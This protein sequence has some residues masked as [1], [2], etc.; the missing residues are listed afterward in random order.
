MKSKP[1]LVVEYD[2]YAIEPSTLSKTPM[3]LNEVIAE[4]LDTAK[5]IDE[6]FKE[7]KTA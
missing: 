7:S 3:P 5:E 1:E 2:N 4:M 6:K